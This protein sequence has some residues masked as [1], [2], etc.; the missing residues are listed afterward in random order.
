MLIGFHDLVYLMN[1]GIRSIAKQC[2]QTGASVNVYNLL[3][4][5]PYVESFLDKSWVDSKLK[6]Y[7][8]WAS[9]NSDPVLQSKFLHR[10]TKFNML[11][12]SIWAAR[13]WEDIR[14]KE[15]PS[16]EPPAG[17]KRLV[18]IACSLAVLEY[19]AGRFLN[20]ETREHLQRRLQ[21]A[22]E[23]WAVIHE[24]NT[25]A[26]FIRTNAKVTPHFLK[27]ASSK[28]ITV[29]WH[30]VNIPVQCKAKRPGSGRAISQELFTELA[31]YIALDVRRKGKK[32]KVTIGSTGEIR[33]EDIVFLRHQVSTDTG[34]ELGPALVTNN[35]RTFTI[36]SQPLKEQF[37]AETIH[38]HISKF[39][40]H[41][42]MIIGEP[43]ESGN[44][45]DEVAVVI[46]EANLD[47]TPWRSL[48][49]SIKDGATQLEGGPIGL[50]ALHYTDPIKDFE[51]LRPGFG[52]IK[53]YIGKL[54]DKYPSTGAVM[55]TSEPD[56]QFP[57]ASGI[58][59][60]RIYYKK[61]W[62]FP[63]D[64]LKEN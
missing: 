51:S 6:E 34:S 41:I 43:A 18:N 56:L 14:Q 24:L 20:T 15:D 46:L 42:V 54:L 37:T 52:P 10:P 9:S 49:N 29:Q 33:E 57:S 32:L 12:A 39:D 21:N 53:A 26:Y 58:A 25:F 1:E 61:P 30:G 3:K 48:R 7:E 40:F 59:K 4:L 11:A 55:L 63:D 23:V 60:P 13:Y 28:E 45:Y 17:A 47:E 50:V 38:Q 5:C 19:N 22:D 64:F 2:S 31:C 36:K 35:T 27:K 44:A 62:P 8:E 16:F